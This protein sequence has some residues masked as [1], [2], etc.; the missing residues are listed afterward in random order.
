M[1]RSEYPWNRLLRYRGLESF[2]GISKM[3]KTT[4]CVAATLLTV[5]FVVSASANMG[6]ASPAFSNGGP[7]PS[8][9]TCDAQGPEDPPNPPLEF[10][11]VHANAKSLVMIMSDP[12]VPKNVLSTGVFDDW[13]IWD[14]S[15]DTKGIK[16]GDLAPWHQ[17]MNGTGKVGYLGPCPMDRE[18]RYFFRLYALDVKLGDAIVNRN[19][20]ADAMKGHIIEE[21][22]LMGRYKRV[23]K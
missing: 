9:Y 17:G 11:G 7:I 2:S 5:I 8:K 19:D 21:A 6:I 22:E 15:P 1:I 14:I 10:S 18:H 16:E 13:V 4:S 20:L 3:C 23:K 12:D